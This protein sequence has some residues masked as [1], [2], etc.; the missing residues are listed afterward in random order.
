MR[1]KTDENLPPEV[2]TLLRESGHDTLS[3]WDEQLRGKPDVDLARACQRERRALITLDTGFANI[4]TYPPGQF[5]G[6]IVL[7]L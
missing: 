3:V 2:P 4:R 6:I 5:P 1:F 7:R